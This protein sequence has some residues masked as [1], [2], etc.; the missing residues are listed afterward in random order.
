MKLLLKNT[1]NGLTPLYPD[2]Y[3]NKKR[4]KLDK[5]YQADIKLSRNYEF[6]CKYHKLIGVSW[7]LL[8][9][10]AQSF[11]KTKEGFRKTIE[12][13][14]GHYELVYSLRLREWVEMAKSISFE[15]CTEEEFQEIYDRVKDVVW[16]LL[17]E[18]NIITIDNFNNILNGF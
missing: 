11:F 9:E 10:K 6:F 2:D 12:V 7:D 17:E 5:V 1:Y 14:A 4:L 8:G 16:G 3:D 15:K 13:S 18:R